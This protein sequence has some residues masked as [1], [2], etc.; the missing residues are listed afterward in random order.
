M[1]NQKRIRINFKVTAGG[2]MTPD[3]TI[4]ADNPELHLPLFEQ[5]II[6]LK[7]IAKKNNWKWPVYEEKE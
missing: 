5:A 4:E 2:V 7:I 6:D 1:E 3:I